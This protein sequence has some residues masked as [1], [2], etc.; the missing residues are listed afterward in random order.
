MPRK[1]ELL[2]ELT[3]QI[4]YG[5]TIELVRGWGGRRLHVPK[6]LDATHPIALT[7]GLVAARQLSYYYGGTELELPAE[8]NALTEVRNN[9]ILRDLD[10][11]RTRLRAPVRAHTS[12]RSVHHKPARPH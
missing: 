7:V 12:T 4:G 1:S 3:T 9:S 5:E 2:D 8:R 11:G 6:D 10:S